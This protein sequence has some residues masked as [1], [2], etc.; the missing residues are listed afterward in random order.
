MKGSYGFKDDRGVH[1]QVDYVA[2]HAG[3][4]AEVKTNEPGT[5]SLN[6]AAVKIHSSAHPYFGNPAVHGGYGAH[7]HGHGGFG[8]LGY[9]HGGYGGH[10]GFG[11]HGYGHGGLGGHA[12]AHGAFGGHGY[13]HGI[14]F[15]HG[16]HGHAYGHGY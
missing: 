12:Y 8:G 4:R 15:G 16:G 9:G 10:G 3:F 11:G 6:P 2:D 5:A 14:G 7:G 13:G 1:R